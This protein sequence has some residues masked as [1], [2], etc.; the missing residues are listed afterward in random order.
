M[1]KRLH[2]SAADFTVPLFQF[3]DEKH[4]HVI[5]GHVRMVL[6]L[7]QVEFAEIWSREQLSN[8]LFSEPVFVFIHDVVNGRMF[9]VGVF[10]LLHFYCLF[11]FPGF[12][13]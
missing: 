12:Y 4:E 10:I 6:E 8:L 9:T 1:V 11:F 2:L 5:S 3:L 13:L 7:S